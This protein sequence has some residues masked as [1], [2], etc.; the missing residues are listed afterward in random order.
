MLMDRKNWFKS[1]GYYEKPMY[2]WHID[3]MFMFLIDAMKIK[4]IILPEDHIIYH[5]EHGGG[6]T[7][8]TEKQLFENLKKRNVPYFTWQDLIKIEKVIRRNF[9]KSIYFNRET[10]GIIQNLKISVR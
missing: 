1:R 9:K 6:W 4:C 10:W 2:S 8:E 7:P 3:S 5:I